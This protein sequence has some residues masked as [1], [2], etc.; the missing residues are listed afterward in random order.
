MKIACLDAVHS[1]TVG[2]GTQGK[3]WIGCPLPHPSRYKP[4]HIASPSLVNFTVLFSTVIDPNWR[5]FEK[6]PMYTKKYTN[7]FA[8]CWSKTLLIVKVSWSWYPNEVHPYM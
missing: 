5:K 7:V 3:K 1:V 6:R 4:K 8:G 2:Q